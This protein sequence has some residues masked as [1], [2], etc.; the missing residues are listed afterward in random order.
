M[1]RNLCAFPG[2]DLHLA[3]PQWPYVTCEICHIHGLNNS[4]R[5]V[6]GM[7]TKECNS[8]ENLI[9]LCRNHHHRID[10]LEPDLYPAERLF[11]MKRDHESGEAD[12]WRSDAEAIAQAVV[13]LVRT[14]GITLTC[15]SEGEASATLED[16]TTEATGTTGPPTFDTSDVESMNNQ[17]PGDDEATTDDP[18]TSQKAIDMINERGAA[19]HTAAEPFREQMR[20]ALAGLQQDGTGFLPPTDEPDSGRA[21]PLRRPQLRLGS[22][23]GAR[24]QFIGRRHRIRERGDR[25]LAQDDRPRRGPHRR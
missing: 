16:A 12:T 22:T 4:A 15:G 20:D 6:P 11:K 19:D 23:T 8:Y 7:S 3:D 10:M 21:Y 1:S 2:C 25:P 17:V 24:C 5:H 13:K 14:E 9:L 18:P